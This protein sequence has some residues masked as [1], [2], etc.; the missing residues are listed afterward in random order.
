M[1]NEMWHRDD[2]SRWKSGSTERV[3]SVFL[4][5]SME[6]RVTGAVWAAG[7]GWEARPGGR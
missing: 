2:V 3:C 7:E 4:R 6:A 5:V 1:S